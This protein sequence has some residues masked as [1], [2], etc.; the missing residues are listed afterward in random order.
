VIAGTQVPSHD[1]SNHGYSR[2]CV[3]LATARMGVSAARPGFH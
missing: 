2:L 3:L 1:I